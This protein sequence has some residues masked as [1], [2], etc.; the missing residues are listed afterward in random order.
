MKILYLHQYFNTPE[1]AGS[2]RSWEF[3]RR[4]AA[5]GHEVHMITSDRNPGPEAPLWRLEERDGVKIHWTPVPYS[6]LDGNRR[7][8]G[9]FFTFAR[10]ASARAA[11]TGGD[12]LI[13]SSTPLTVALPALSASRKLGIPMIF[14]VRDLW[15]QVPVAMGELR[16]FWTIR[17][18]EWLERR[19]YRRAAHIVALSEG[20]REGILARGVPAGKVSVI[21]NASDRELFEVPAETGRLFRRTRSWI[22]DRPLVVYCGTLGRV[23]G[24]GYLA[25]I[26]RETMRLDPEIRFL[27]VG[28]GRE[29][30]QIRERARSAGVLE[31]N[32]FMIDPLPKR[33]IPAIYSAADLT[34]SLVIDNRA[35]WANSANKFFDSLA[36]GRPI[37]INHEGWQA[38]LIRSTGAGLVVP[39]GDAPAAA[40]AIV[41]F[42][43]DSDRLRRAGEAA[44]ALARERFDRDL[45]AAQWLELIERTAAG[46]GAE[47]S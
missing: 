2:T 26:A 18:A 19:A 22:G 11:E 1:M 6:N 13:A 10:R 34:C 7:R 33:E 45:L 46:T 36:A 14:E 23:N 40:A 12:L 15:P 37:L 44:S 39:P 20:M 17:F 32:F 5:A 42:L 16:S 29:A 41:S 47:V 35:L 21:P 3:A 25:E 9:A 43:S 30:E 8:L 27:V 24:I 4:F 28:E 38:D 31:R